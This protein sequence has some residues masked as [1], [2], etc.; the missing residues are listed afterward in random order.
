MKTAQG[1]RGDADAPHTDINSTAAMSNIYR[2]CRATQNPVYVD[3]Q[4]IT[5]HLGNNFEIFICNKKS[6]STKSAMVLIKCV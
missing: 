3:L 2:L 6:I 1:G 5:Q 4:R